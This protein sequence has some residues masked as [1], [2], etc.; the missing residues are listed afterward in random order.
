[1]FIKNINNNKKIEKSKLI[2]ESIFDQL[3]NFLLK[4]RKFCSKLKN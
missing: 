3:L 1:M 4:L 2:F